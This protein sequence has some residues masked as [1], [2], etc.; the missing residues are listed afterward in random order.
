MRGPRS[1]GLSQAAGVCVAPPPPPA[2]TPPYPLRLAYPRAIRCPC[3]LSQAPGGAPCAVPA[4]FE[5][6]A[7]FVPFSPMAELTA[8]ISVPPPHTQAC[9][10]SYSVPKLR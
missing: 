1:V 4:L 7:I 9:S 3:Q 8:V 6:Y 10:D 2:S 5:K